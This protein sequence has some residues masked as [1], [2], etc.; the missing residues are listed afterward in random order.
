MLETPMNRKS[1]RWD[2]GFVIVESGA[3]PYLICVCVSQTQ[4]EKKRLTRSKLPP[5]VKK[6]VANRNYLRF[7]VYVE[8]LILRITNIRVC[9]SQ[10]QI[11]P[12]ITP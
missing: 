4:I 1:S 11:W 5:K 9:E 8:S 3:F 12:T 7:S 6:L 10:T 2:V